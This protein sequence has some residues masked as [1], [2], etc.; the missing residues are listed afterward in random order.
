M[1]SL[2]LFQPDQA[3][4][5]GTLMRLS[6]CMD[7][8]IHIIHPCGFT[9]SKQ[10][11]KRSAMDYFDHVSLYEHDDFE[12]FCNNTKEQRKILLTTKTDQ[13]FTDFKFQKN[14]ILILGQESSGAPDYVHQNVHGRV[15]IPMHPEMR[16]INIAISASMVLS[17]ALR[18]TDNFPK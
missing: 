9:F 16:S 2:A 1:V 15:T 4:N 12:D 17:E 18:Q 10:A 7:S 8:Q 13:K 6:A 14:D 5:C 3:G 11:L